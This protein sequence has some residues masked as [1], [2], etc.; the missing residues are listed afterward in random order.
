MPLKLNFRGIVPTGSDAAALLNAAGDAVLIERGR[1]RNLVLVCPCGCGE[2]FPINLDSRAGPAWR[3]YG[4]PN[5][6]LSI[7]PSVWREN[8]CE[9]HYIVWRGKIYL[10]G[11]YDSDLEDTT[12]DETFNTLLESVHDRLPLLTLKSFRE[13]ADEL[14]LI[15]WDVLVA[16]RH[17][18][19]DGIAQEGRDKLKGHFGRK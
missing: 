1:P 6:G 3:L 9:S 11:R 13:I 2:R 19:R 4:D 15:P 7:F 16:C 18:V 17:L 14:R 5:E 10:F 12:G 8:G